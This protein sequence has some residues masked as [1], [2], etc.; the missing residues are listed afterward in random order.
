M[1]WTQSLPHQFYGLLDL[2]AIAPFYLLV[3]LPG[4][5]LRVLRIVRLVRVFKLSHYNSAIEDLMQAIQGE[6]GTCQ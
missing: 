4:L 1:A 5:D 6:N 3:L 2:A